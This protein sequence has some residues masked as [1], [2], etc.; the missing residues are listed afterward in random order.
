MSLLFY[1]KAY[2]FCGSATTFSLYFFESL[3]IERIYVT[4]LSHIQGFNE[5]SDG[6]IL[7]F[8][9]SAREGNGTPLQYSCL[10]NPIGGGAW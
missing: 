6:H 8:I 5:W 9:L 4:T 2:K 3:T 1:Q 7:N 10:G